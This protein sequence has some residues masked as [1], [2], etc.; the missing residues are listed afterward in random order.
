ML[1]KNYIQMHISY[2]DIGS[3][4]EYVIQWIVNSLSVYIYFSFIV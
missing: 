1:K 4:I 3:V 2:I